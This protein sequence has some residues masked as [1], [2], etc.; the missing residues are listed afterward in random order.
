MR[1]ARRDENLS[2]YETVVLHLVDGVELPDALLVE[3][4][5]M[6]RRADGELEGRELASLHAVLVPEVLH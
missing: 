5:P 2:A 4:H 1:D 6:G 3:H